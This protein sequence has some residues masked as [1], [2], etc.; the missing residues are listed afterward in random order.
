MFHLAY[1]PSQEVCT[2]VQLHI[3]ETEK[4]IVDCL[5][6]PM[7]AVPVQPYQAFWPES[8]RKL[9]EILGQDYQ[10]H[11][12]GPLIFC[13]L[14]IS[15]HP[16]I[17]LN[18]VLQGFK[19]FPSVRHDQHLIVVPFPQCFS[20]FFPSNVRPVSSPMSCPSGFQVIFLAL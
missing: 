11:P 19:Q 2:N 20:M 7:E 5:S 3:S 17:Y 4:I 6:G 18:L 14:I 15:Y 10:S 12:Q 13:G 8:P 1:I 9:L 16:H